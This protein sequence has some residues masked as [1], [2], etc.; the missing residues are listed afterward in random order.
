SNH[1]KKQLSLLQRAS[2][3]T[4]HSFC[5]E[6]VRDHAYLIDIDPGFRIANEMEI[7][8]FKQDVLDDLFEEWYGADDVRAD[9]FF[10][11]V[12]RFSSDR[13]DI[14]ME[15][16]I[17][18]LYDFSIQNPQPKEWL[19]SLAAVY[20]IPEN[21]QESELHFLSILKYEVRNQLDALRKQMEKAKWVTGENDGPYEYLTAIEADL[22][23]L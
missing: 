21:W 1:L 18:D 14:D 12:D 19:D 10:T 17:L 23:G 22:E 3:S 13:S 8:L 2:I 6:V 16:L 7:D 5:L 9:E 15:K 20:D 4:L 11:V